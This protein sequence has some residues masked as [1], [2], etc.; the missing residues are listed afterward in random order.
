MT[1][2]MKMFVNMIVVIIVLLP[3][4]A[5]GTESEWKKYLDLKNKYYYIDKQQFGEISCVI[6][7]P[8]MNK[9]IEQIK[10]QIAHLKDKV[11]IRE[12]LSSFSLTYSPTLGLTFSDPEFD[13]IVINT[14]GLADPERVRQGIDMMKNGFN[15]QVAGV[16]DILTGLFDDYYH[17]KKENYK[18]L[19]VTKNKDG[20]FVKY[21][22]G[23]SNIQWCPVSFLHVIDNV[24]VL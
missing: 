3:F 23:S 21:V 20:Y 17:P 10:N 1:K 12:N 14:E 2:K 11:E 24:F 18:D 7:V 22:S 19:T 6:D 13:V 16:K 15:M 9:L 8:L 4:S 5:Y